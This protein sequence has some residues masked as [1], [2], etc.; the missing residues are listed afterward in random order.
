MK[1]ICIDR[2]SYHLTIGKVYEAEPINPILGIWRE[3]EVILFTY[4]IINDKGLKHQVEEDLFIEMSIFRN[5]KIDQILK[6]K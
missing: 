3:N 4:W 1:V 5:D 6:L 2:G